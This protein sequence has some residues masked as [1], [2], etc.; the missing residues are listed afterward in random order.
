MSFVADLF[1]KMLFTHAT[2]A[3]VADLSP[4]F[5]LVELEGAEL[6][7]TRGAPGDKLQVRA[8]GFAMRTYT[9]ID[10]D[11]ERGRTRICAYVHGD[12]PGA[13]WVSALREGDGCSFFGPRSSLALARSTGP[14]VLFGDETSIAVA[15]SLRAL[16]GTAAHIVLEASDAETV[17]P[18][19]AALGIDDASVFVRAPDDTHLR[20]VGDEI[21]R[22]LTPSSSVFLTG[23]AHSI[24]GV[25]AHLRAAGAGGSIK[26][27][28]YWA[29]GKTGLD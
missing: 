26:A 10:W 23:G 3:R 6:T 21:V 15:S 27:K 1:D 18:V 17:Q 9:P 7:Q 20:A 5:R 22:R 19:L 24:V 2:V 11:R 4:R 16:R 13:R 28:A 12:G 29:E 14:V 8:A 25:R